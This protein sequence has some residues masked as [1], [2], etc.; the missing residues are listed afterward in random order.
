MPP[1]EGD[2]P[3]DAGASKLSVLSDG[4]KHF[5]VVDD[6]LSSERL[7]YGDGKSFWQQRVTGG[8]GQRESAEGA[9]TQRSMVFWEPRV[10]QRYEASFDLKDGRYAITCGKRETEFKPL[11]EAESQKL[12]KAGTLLSPHWPYRAHLLARDDTGRYY[13]VDR[14]REPEDSKSFRVFSGP[15][16]DL[17]P[18]KMTN[19]VSDSEGEIFSTR[20]GTL[21]LV[22]NKNELRWVAGASNKKL[23]LVPVE[24]N[25]V[26]IYSD[27]GVYTGQRLGTPCDDL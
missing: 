16:G 25:H 13:Y 19:V 9:W 22:L 11:P 12:L 20:T 3:L 24:D 18:L 14:R 4:K 10:A 15:K 21:R 27:L 7:L 2:T 23:L 6:Q 26:M 1:G 17:K 8:G 5:L